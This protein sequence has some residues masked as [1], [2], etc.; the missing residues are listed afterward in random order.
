MKYL[1]THEK[2]LKKSIGFFLN[3]AKKGK[4]GPERNS[5][6]K[7]G[8][9]NATRYLKYVVPMMKMSTTTTAIIIKIDL[10]VSM[11]FP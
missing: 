6:I 9:D 1:K 4:S 11:N 10:I 8:W 5:F 3:Q 7:Q 2:N